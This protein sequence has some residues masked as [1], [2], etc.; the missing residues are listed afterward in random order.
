[1]EKPVIEKCWVCNICK[2]IVE[3][4]KRFEH[5]IKNHNPTEF[6]TYAEVVKDEWELPSKK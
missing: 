2:S 3:R 1:M 4:D 6:F 5:L